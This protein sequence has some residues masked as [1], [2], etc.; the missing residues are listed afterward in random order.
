MILAKVKGSVTATLKHPVYVGKKVLAVQ[1]INDKT[2]KEKGESFLAV[3]SVQAGIG[4][5][6]LV[7]REGSTARQILGNDNDPFHSVIVGIVDEVEH[8]TYNK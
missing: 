5:I 7:A 2:F 4:D 8:G 1:A 6:V 3:D